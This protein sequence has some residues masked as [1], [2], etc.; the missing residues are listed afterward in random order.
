MSSH[1][2]LADAL[3][4]NGTIAA[5]Y[6]AAMMFRWYRLEEVFPWQKL[7]IGALAVA[8]AFGLATGWQLSSRVERWSWGMAFFAMTGWLVAVAAAMLGSMYLR[9]LM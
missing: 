8:L 2:R 1:S 3:A 6:L 7:G 5:L 9:S 4:K